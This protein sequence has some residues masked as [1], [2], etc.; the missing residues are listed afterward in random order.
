MWTLRRKPKLRTLADIQANAERV[1]MDRPSDT[2]GTFWVDAKN[3]GGRT[4]AT[5]LLRG[6]GDDPDARIIEAP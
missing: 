2:P 4:H 6:A 1:F 3:V 5:F